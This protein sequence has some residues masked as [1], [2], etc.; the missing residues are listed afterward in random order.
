VVKNHG[1]FVTVRSEVGR[2]SVFTLHLPAAEKPFDRRPEALAAPEK[3]RGAVSD[4][5]ILVVDD[6]E[7][8][9]FLARDILEGEGY[10]VL[11]AEDGAR[12]LEIYREHQ[13][14]IG[15][16]VLDLIMPKLGGGEVFLKMKEMDPGVHVLVS[17]GYSQEGKAQEILSGGALGFVQ[18]PFHVRD[19]ISKVRQGLDGKGGREGG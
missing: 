14:E 13:G 12:A 3:S 10:R 1:G 9:R 17:S 19:L 4:Q 5:T 2:G 18:K 16:V 7:N 15:L 6:E 11:V 8:I